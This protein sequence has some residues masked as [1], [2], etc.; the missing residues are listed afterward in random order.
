MSHVRVRIVLDD[1][2]APCGGGNVYVTTVPV[3]NSVP[4]QL[5][6]HAVAAAAGEAVAGFIR[7]FAREEAERGGPW[8]PAK[9]PKTPAA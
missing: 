2:T 4:G 7:T 8:E 1:G 6:S 3:R 5:D 9:W